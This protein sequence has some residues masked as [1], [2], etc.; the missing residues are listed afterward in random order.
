M[1]VVH[2]HRVARPQDRAHRL[3]KLLVDR[4][5]G[6][7]PLLLRRARRRLLARRPRD[8]VVEVRPEDVV[9]EPIVVGSA[10]RL[11]TK[12]GRIP[13]VFQSV[14]AA[15]PARP[16][17]RRRR[18]TSR[19]TPSAR[20]ARR[21]GGDHPPGGRCSQ[22]PATGHFRLI[23]SGSRL[24]TRSRAR[25]A[26]RATSGRA[27]RRGVWAGGRAPARRRAS[28][29]P[30]RGAGRR[31]GGRRSRPA[32]RALRPPARRSRRRPRSVMYELVEPRRFG[33]LGGEEEAGVARGEEEEE[34]E[35]ARHRR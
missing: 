4:S 22:P 15:A 30:T 35:P 20:R 31:R 33:L 26:A 12:I 21:R 13:C 10:V 7:P 5:V 18:R 25:S 3:G 23:C 1:V 17:S 8:D 29:A 11:S 19:P 27:R 24:A 14:A 28:G 32:R 34:R 9:A 2:P 6:R 16:A